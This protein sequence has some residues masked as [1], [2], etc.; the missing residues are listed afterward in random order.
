MECAPRCLFFRIPLLFPVPFVCA[1]SRTVLGTAAPKGCGP[2][3]VATK[4]RM[5]AQTVC[6]HIIVHCGWHESM[7]APTPP[8]AA[9]PV[10]GAQSASEQSRAEQSRAEQTAD[11]RGEATNCTTR[12][13]TVPSTHRAACGVCGRRQTGEAPPQ[14]RQGPLSPRQPHGGELPPLLTGVQ[15]QADTSAV[16][17]SALCRT[18]WRAVLSLV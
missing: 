14:T 12:R 10:C 9:C 6:T 8:P 18:L 16:K 5:E 3:A 13:G 4:T 7:S 15:A 11:P 2:S 1:V 17:R